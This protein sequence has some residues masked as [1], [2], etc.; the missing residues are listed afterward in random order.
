MARI[1]DIIGL[2]IVLSM[3][4]LHAH[5]LDPDLREMLEGHQVSLPDDENSHCETDEEGQIVCGDA[6]EKLRSERDEREERLEKLLETIERKLQEISDQFGNIDA[7]P[8]S[9]TVT[10]VLWG[11]LIALI[12]FLTLLI[13]LRVARRYRSNPRMTD[14][15]T[16]ESLLQTLERSTRGR[17]ADELADEGAYGPAVHALLLDALRYLR[18]E[19]PIIDIPSTTSREVVRAA[20]PARRSHLAVL[21][22]LV[23]KSRFAL[24]KVTAEEFEGASDAHRALKEVPR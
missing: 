7:M 4:P 12:V 3:V 24:E 20:S 16:P 2:I 21:V 15:D 23:E 17:A 9:E 13:G 18:D 8:S 1:R 5:G 6:A 14:D 11:A 10:R 22:E 19:I